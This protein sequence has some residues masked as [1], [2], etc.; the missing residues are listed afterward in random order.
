MTNPAERHS[1]RLVDGIRRRSLQAV[2][3]ALLLS[4]AA[5]CS[6]STPQQKP[7]SQAAPP[8]VREVKPQVSLASLKL[9]AKVQFPDERTPTSQDIAQ[10]IADFANAIASGADDRMQSMVG[11]RDRL[12]LSTLIESGEWRRQTESIEVVRVCAINEVDGNTFQV[13]FGVQDSLGAFLSA[14]EAKGSGASWTFTGFAAAPRFASKASDLDGISLTPLA[15][16]EATKPIENTIAAPEQP[17]EEEEEASQGASPKA[18]PG[19]L[20][21]DR[22]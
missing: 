11:E 18:P 14:W 16:P 13:G 3:A 8:P 5:G 10:A 21:K 20:W 4:G 7:Q 2:L 6:D 15:L 12:L 17:K 19:T 1:S 9:H 22:E